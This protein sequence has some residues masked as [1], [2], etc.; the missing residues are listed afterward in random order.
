MR[1]KK[2]RFNLAI[3]YT[4]ILFL[5]GPFISTSF[6]FNPSD[7]NT[8]KSD[9]FIV[10]YQKASPD[11]VAEILRRAEYYYNAI[12]DDFGFTR[13]GDFWTW[14]NRARI[15]LYDNS[16]DYKKIT[17]S[18]GWSGAGVNVNTREIYT[19][20]NM[21]N[22]YD[23]ILPHEIGHIIFRE[24]TGYKR[25]YPLW[26]EEGIACYLERGQRDERMRIARGLVRSKIFISLE[27]LQKI[28]SS[29]ILLIP[30]I[31]YSE[32][33]SVVAF[34]LKDYG[35]DKFVDFCRALRDLRDDQ[36]WQVALKD[37]YKF[38]D[39]NEMNLRWTNFLYNTGAGAMANAAQY[40][41]G[42]MAG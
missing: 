16:S 40:V 4:S 11:H 3:I 9:H 24:F 39:L 7:W 14:D 17:N 8:E 1:K 13:F 22:F 30:D 29:D 2:K 34:L 6:S 10:Y 31:F 18:P 12:T 27:D 26:L 28:K 5:A 25:N 20:V 38:K 35:K 36:D 19:F 23:T 21:E 15:Y 42:V 37:V 33:A 32:S 41:P